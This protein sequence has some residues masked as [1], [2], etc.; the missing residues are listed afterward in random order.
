MKNDQQNAILM[1]SKYD[2]PYGYNEKLGN[3][4]ESFWLWLKLGM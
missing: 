4:T 3:S 2:I 1:Q